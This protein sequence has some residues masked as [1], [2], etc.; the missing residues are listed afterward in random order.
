MGRLLES[1]LLRFARAH[2]PGTMH[3]IDSSPQPSPRSTRRGR[4]RRAWPRGSTRASLRTGTGCAQRRPPAGEHLPRVQPKPPLPSPRPQSP[5]QGSRGGERVRV[6]G[7]SWEAPGCVCSCTRP[8]N[9]EV[10]HGFRVPPRMEGD[11]RIRG[12][13][14]LIR[15]EVPGKRSPL[16]Q[17]AKVR[18]I[19]PIP[20][21]L[22]GQVK[23]LRR[24]AG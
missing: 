15:G 8:G 1:V 18:W 5:L 14:S 24:K 17:R 21:H 7:G 6:R 2:G 20:N 11:P 13:A 9:R 12:E 23:T 4:H 19:G 10:P 16:F 3:R 22:T